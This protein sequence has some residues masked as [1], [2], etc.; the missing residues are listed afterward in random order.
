[1][2][3]C[4][5][6]P[7][8]EVCEPRGI[9]THADQAAAVLEAADHPCMASAAPQDQGYPPQPQVESAVWWGRFFG[10]IV[11][12]PSR[13]WAAPHP[14]PHGPAG[15]GQG[16][17]HASDPP[18]LPPSTCCCCCCQ[19]W[20]PHESTEQPARSSLSRRR[21]TS[22]PSAVPRQAALTAGDALRAEASHHPAADK[23][24]PLAAP[25]AAPVWPCT[26]RP[27]PAPSPHHHSLHLP[28][29][30]H[31]RLWRPSAPRRFEHRSGAPL[32]PQGI[33][34]PPGAA[35][36]LARPG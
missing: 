23:I 21:G 22:L 14:P 11:Q 25:P 1:M 4:I 36:L 3:E 9:H 15:G 34:L 12:G 16:L 26:H 20:G 33:L 24:S 5:P 17:P 18:A 35:A 13:G 29:P 30:G 31:Q 28:F 27:H 32:L 7:G 10:W 8:G 19:S 2:C 6:G